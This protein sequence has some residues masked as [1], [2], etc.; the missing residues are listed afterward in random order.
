MTALPLVETLLRDTRYAIRVLRK[1][2]GFTVTAVLTLAM[3]VAINAAVFSVVDG[4]LL[5]PLPFAEPERLLLMNAMVEGGG[6]RGSRTSQ[7]GVAWVTVRDHATTVDAAVF[8]TWASGVNVVAG[9]RALHV[10]QQKVGSGF[11]GVLGVRPVFGREF[12]ADED[13][14]GGAAAV[15]LSHDFWRG[16]LGGDPAVVGRSITLRGAPHTVVG[17]LPAGVPTG[18]KADVWT[19]LRATTDGEGGGENFQILLRLKAGAT[20]AA[21]DADLQRLGPEIDRLRPPSAGTTITY[22]T[23]PL[24]QGLTETLRQ[25]LLMLWTAVGVVLLIACVNLAGLMF[26][27]GAGRQR[28]IATRLALGSGRAA[29]VRQLV[30]ESALLAVTGAALGCILGVAALQALTGLAEHALDLWQPIALDARAIIA[31]GLIA[32]FATIVFGVVPALQSTRIS[33]QQGLSSRGTRTVAGAGSHLSRRAAVVVQVALG[34]M[35]LVGAGL[36]ARTFTHLRGL[37]PG[38][39]GGGVYAASVS[40]QDARYQSSQDVLRLTGGAL[41]RLRETPGIES[42]AVSLGLPY[43]RLL[44]LG[45]RHLDGA[46]VKNKPAMTSATYIAGDYFS[47]LRIPVRRG[48]LFDTRD[49]SSAP[50]VVIV[51]ET[52]VREYFGGADPVGRRIGIAGMEREIVAVVGDVQLKPGFGERGPLAPMPLAYIPLAQTSDG[53]LRLMHGWFS[54]ALIVRAQGSADAVTPALRRAVDRVDPLLPFAEL[55]SMEAVQLQ[56]VALPRLLMVLLLTLA[57]AAAALTAV[58]MHGLISASVTERTREL[59]IRMALGATASRAIRT[60]VMP[61]LAIAAA[62]IAVGSVAA[63]SGVTLLRSFVWGVSP[64]DPVT[65]ITVAAFFVI[66]AGTASVVPALRILKLDPATTL[67][68]E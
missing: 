55:R 15:L 38:F 44:N 34:V 8:S 32:L 58:G 31:A 48:R 47:T 65:F 68:A 10:D 12:T 63:L 35:L 14:R 27:R 26:A 2:P 17:I 1:S 16:T 13:R 51:N 54:T 30:V 66:L 62:G 3:A 42:A 7:H 4:V 49:T 46:E 5:K 37:E 23:V 36:L 41:D 19:P 56:A 21:A 39:D 9:D 59:G 24:Q 22:G 61:G 25:P 29:I 11:F 53:M 40:L 45:F 52:F 20:R 50:G 64:T 33:A 43:Q 67:R 57:G 28:E 60:L 6:E 18:V